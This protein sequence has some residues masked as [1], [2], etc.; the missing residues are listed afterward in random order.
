M[1]LRIGLVD[2]V[3]DLEVELGDDTDVEALRK[4]VDELLGRVDGILW[5]TDKKGNQVA[6][7][8]PKV[9]YVVIGS[10]AEKGRI[11]FG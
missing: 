6:V 11:G 10:A 7:S 1:E 4:Q 8:A 2:S 3:R 9:T 5:V